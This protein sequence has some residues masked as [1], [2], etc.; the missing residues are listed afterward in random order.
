[1]L[2]PERSLS[3]V[4]TG[5]FYNC[6]TF[7]ARLR[8]SG[9]GLPAYTNLRELLRDPNANKWELYDLN[10]DY[11]QAHNVADKYPEKLKELVDTFDA[12]A[13][14]NNVYPL[15]PLRGDMPLLSNGRSFQ[16]E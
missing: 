14:R 3:P 11:S 12:E 15:F 7:L 16:R 5:P 9:A 10:T 2:L 8:I 13:K 1:L 4:A 6:H